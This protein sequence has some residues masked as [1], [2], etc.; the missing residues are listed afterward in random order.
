MGNHNRLLGVVKGMDGI[1]TG[2]TRA[3][4]FNLV[5]SVERD[6]RSIVAVVLGG[7]SGKS[8]NEQMA[9]IIEK[10]IK[11][12]SRGGDALIVAK[13][14]GSSFKETVEVASAPVPE[15][16][17]VELTTLASEDPVSQRIATAHVVSDVSFQEAVEKQGPTFDIAAIEAKLIAMS[18]HRLPIPTPAPSSGT[19]DPIITSTQ[20]EETQLA[21]SAEPAPAPAAEMAEQVVRGWHIQIGAT[22]SADQAAALLDKAR[23]ASGKAL[24]DVTDHTETVEKNGETL[25]RARFA[26]FDSK[27]DAWAACTKLKKKKF[28]CIAIAN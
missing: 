26:G 2:Y 10:N 18:K 24:S 27:D 15:K 25:Y 8:R 11:K 3:S 14:R 6:G 16:R 4:G 22:P 19:P 17:P 20:S 9:A 5:S 13:P 12:A 23:S 21:Y 28:A 7:K 1:K